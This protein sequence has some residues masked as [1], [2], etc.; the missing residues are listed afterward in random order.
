M[1]CSFFCHSAQLPL[2]YA[3]IQKEIVFYEKALEDRPID[4]RRI[5]LKIASSS[6]QIVFLNG[7]FSKLSQYDV[8]E[9]FGTGSLQSF[10]TA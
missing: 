9:E 8:S 4:R 1:L 2:L 7:I 10:P 3:K 6:G 5:Q